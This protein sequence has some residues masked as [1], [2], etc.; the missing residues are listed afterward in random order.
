M[1]TRK[2][3]PERRNEERKLRGDERG[4]ERVMTIRYIIGVGSLSTPFHV[5]RIIAA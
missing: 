5:A 4:K 1:I 3:I 2:A